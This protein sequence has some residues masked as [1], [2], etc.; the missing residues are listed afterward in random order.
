[1]R[2]PIAAPTSTKTGKP[3]KN[4]S[5]HRV[6]PRAADIPHAPRDPITAPK[7][8]APARF[9]RLVVSLKARPSKVLFPKKNPPKLQT[10]NPI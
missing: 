4:G 8:T 6:R 3:K 5:G 7:A 1:M 9:G 2:L 10:K